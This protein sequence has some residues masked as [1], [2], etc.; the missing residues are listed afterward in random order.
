MP[1]NIGTFISSVENVPAVTATNNGGNAVLGT[2]Q[3]G[4][5]VMGQSTSSWGVGAQSTS[6]TAVQATSE[7]G[8]GVYGQ[9]GSTDGVHGKSGTGT[10]VAGI[11]DT[12]VGVMGQSTSSWGVGAQST[13]NTAV[14]ATSDTGYAVYGQSGSTDGVHGKSGTG[15]GVA[16]ESTSGTGLW[17]KG[18]PAGY[19]E[20]N[21]TVTGTVTVDQDIV[22]ANAD[23]AEEFDV[24]DHPGG[25]EPGTV[26]V[27]G[28]DEALHP[29]SQPYDRR[30][31]GVVSGGGDY[32]PALVLD[33][34]E[35]SRQRSPVALVGKVC[36]KVDARSEPVNVGDLLTT[37]PTPGHA[38]RA[39]DQGRAFG[40]VIGKA[41]QPLASGRG[42]IT[43]LVAL[44]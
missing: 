23:C 19:F 11:S 1:D 26:M 34:R 37:S 36:C 15:T 2:S 7:T 9:S 21:V 22:L 14:Q 28:D 27:L 13:S 10:G 3:S 5:G 29:S 18:T 42:L 20:G 16:G 35:S 25:A 41:L 38:M 33:R 32:R 8:Y 39:T 24:G 6:N 30:V 43:I 12:G 17:A 4:V 44:Q 31:A 40:A